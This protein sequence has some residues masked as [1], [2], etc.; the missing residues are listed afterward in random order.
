MRLK[1]LVEKGSDYRGK[2]IIGSEY[3]GDIKFFDRLERYSTTNK[4]NAILASAK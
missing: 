1:G 4:V 2:N 3:C